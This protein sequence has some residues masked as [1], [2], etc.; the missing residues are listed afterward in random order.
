MNFSL[1]VMNLISSLLEGTAELGGQRDQLR[2]KRRIASLVMQP[3]HEARAKAE[4][5]ASE[6]LIT[7]GSKG[8]KNPGP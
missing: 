2:A 4:V 1:K 6:P 3:R 8:S 7:G 5:L